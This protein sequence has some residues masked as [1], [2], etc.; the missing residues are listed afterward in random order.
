MTR[1]SL[2]AS[3][4]GVLLNA[5]L[6][7]IEAGGVRKVLLDAKGDILVATADD[8]V[9]RLAVGADGQVLTADSSTATGVKWAN[10]TASAVAPLDTANPDFPFLTDYAGLSLNGYVAGDLSISQ[11]RLYSEATKSAG[12]YLYTAPPGGDWTATLKGVVGSAGSCMFGL[13]ALPASG[14]GVAG[15]FYN[16]A[17]NGPLIGTIDASGAYSGTSAASAGPQGSFILGSTTDAWYRLRKVGSTYYSSISA[18]G[19]RWSQEASLAGPAT[20]TKVGFGC[21]YNNISMFDIDYFD[22]S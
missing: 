2:G 17:P 4:W 3:N 21:W 1:P 12:N 10:S 20:P 11:G 15:G 16:S 9:V 18:N 22:I 6:D 8:N 5:D 7:Q 19:R 14:G 13:L